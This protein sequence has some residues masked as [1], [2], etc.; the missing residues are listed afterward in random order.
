[1]K[2]PLQQI[3]ADKARNHTTRRF[4]GESVAAWRVRVGLTVPA[5]VG[6]PSLG[7]GLLIAALCL[8]SVGVAASLFV[9]FH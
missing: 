1:M 9:L 7:E 3:A 6:R 8:L 4:R 2:T 5:M